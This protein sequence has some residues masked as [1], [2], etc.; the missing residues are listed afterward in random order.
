MAGHS[1]WKT[2]K[3][4]K[5]A[6]DNKRGALFTRLIREITMAA[7]LGGG[8]AG[9]NPR[10]RTAI[11]NAKAVSMP[12]DNIDRAIKKGTGE[13]E[14]VDYV[15]VLYEAYG[16]GGVAIMIAAVTDNPTRT[17][18]DVRH[19][20]SRNHG[21]MGTINSVAFMFDRKGQM[22]VAAEGVAE[23]ALMEAA[24]EAGADDVVNDGE[25]FVISTDPG[26]LHA[27]KEGLEGRKYKVENAELAWVPKNTVKV[28]GENATQLL[29]LLE[30]L[31]ELDDVQK[32]DANFEM[33]DDTMADA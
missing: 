29:K 9:G 5:A 19:K 7:K 25:S 10:L 23:E 26:A 21:N 11:D 24:L 22:S 6:T 17:V 27:T 20:L 18:A 33:D 14:G 30:A 28:E 1:K 31:E 4:A 8:D 3:R 2:I 16:P 12:K 15:E 32:V 13:L